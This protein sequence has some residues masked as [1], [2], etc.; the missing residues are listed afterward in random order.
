[1]LDNLT[2]EAAATLLARRALVGRALREKSA[3]G[4]MLDQI[5]QTASKAWADTGMRNNIIGAGVGALAGGGLGLLSQSRRPKERRNSLAGLMQG[6]LLGAGVGG[7][8]T[9]AAQQI[10]AGMK[11]NTQDQ[12]NNVQKEQDRVN[13]SRL[14]P[15]DT[16]AATTDPS[17]GEVV[18][19]E[20]NKNPGTL[21]GLGSGLAAPFTNPWSVQSYI[22]AA[23][24]MGFN[25]Q[26]GVGSTTRMGGSL[27]GGGHLGGRLYDRAFGTHSIR[28]VADT[29]PAEHTPS[30]RVTAL[31]GRYAA[32]G[33]EP[34]VPMYGAGAYNH[35]GVR[36]GD[37]R[38]VMRTGGGWPRRI[39]QIAGALG[40]NAATRAGEDYF[41]GNSYQKS[42]N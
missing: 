21:A 23:N 10:A 28:N 40:L 22:D 19:P 11:P 42:H 30:R 9:F 26:H 14:N 15:A 33:Q 41:Y 1:M 39:V 36:P 18:I 27:I 32:R 3:A 24:A 5:G 12:I 13:R 2:T 6:A 17:T 29:S 35:G 8:G 31:S 20:V 37:L 34:H 16:A 4:G 7:A 38:K 25:P